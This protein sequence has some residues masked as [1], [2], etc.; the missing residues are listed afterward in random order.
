MTLSVSEIIKALT[1]DGKISDGT[2]NNLIDMKFFDSKTGIG[3]GIDGLR[4]RI[5]VLPGQENVASFTTKNADF[6]PART[7]SW[8]EKDVSLPSSATLSCRSDFSIPAV[9]EAV[10]V[11]FLGLIELQEK[12][13]SSGRAIWQMKEL[14]ENGFKVTFSDEVLLGLIGETLLINK[15]RNPESIIR[16]WHSNPTDI[17]DFSSENLRLEVKTSKNT[18]RNHNFS[19]NQVGTSLDSKLM[20]ASIVLN[21]VEVGSTL[22][23]V[24]DQICG[25]LNNEIAQ[26]FVERVIAILGCNPEFAND[27]KFDQTS[28]IDSLVFVEG[29]AVPRPIST[30]GVISM[31]WLASLVD[32]PKVDLNLE[33]VMDSF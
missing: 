19:S 31:S 7:I 4:Q 17:F 18:S 2:N 23:E 10:A 29:G 22:K 28:S 30:P 8:L 14:F 20:I 12:F 32:A 24:I 21:T 5:L 11:V 1:D 26:L 15:A 33:T 9:I 27:L 13:G 25:K 16:Y 3:I 6:D